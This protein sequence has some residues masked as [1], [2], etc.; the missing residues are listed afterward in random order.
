MRRI[1]SLPNRA[2]ADALGDY[3]YLHKIENTVAPEE[4][5]GWALWVHDDGHLEA[6][7]RSFAEFLKNPKDPRFQQVSQRARDLRFR[8]EKD[9]KKSR[10]R[11]VDLR[12]QWHLTRTGIGSLTLSLIIISVGVALV[13]RLGADKTIIQPL[14]ISDYEVMGGY[15]QWRAGLPQIMNGQIWR[16]ITPIFIHFGFLHLLFNMLWLKDLGTMIERHQG[17]WLLALQVVVIG[18]LSNLGQY[19]VSGPTFG[20]MSGVVYGLLGYI[21]L[22]GR[23]DPGSG[24]YLHKTIVVWMIVWF[25]IC[26]LGLVGHVANAA[27]GVGLVVGMLWGYLSSGH[28]LKVIRR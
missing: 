19:A 7:E 15:V 5:G 27:H 20:G 1:G 25:G 2:Q 13:S 9:E 16:L 14:F 21:W 11:T 22:R 17:T 24:L 4:D 26:L 8:R 23:F 18:V 3:L 12:T 28:L 10:A 6:A